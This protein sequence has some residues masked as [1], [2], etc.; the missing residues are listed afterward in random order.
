MRRCQGMTLIELM[1]VMAILSSVLGLL[2]LLGDNL[3]RSAVSQGLRVQTQDSVR[4][5]MQLLAR[6]L[7]QGAISSINYAALPS[8]SITY[9]RAE[10]ADGNGT[11]VDVGQYLELGPQKT[12]QRDL[13]D[14]NNDGETVTQLIATDGVNVKVIANHILPNEDINA[15]GVLDAGEDTNANGVLDRGVWFETLGNG[16]IRITL[17]AEESPGPRDALVTSQ[18]VE[19]V[20]PRN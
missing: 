6:E 12:I 11:A 9:R 18:L 8:G 5:G 7:R 14:A 17:Q 3:Q 4:V 1:I 2:F 13:A 20:V 15:D 10:D 19:I 16:T